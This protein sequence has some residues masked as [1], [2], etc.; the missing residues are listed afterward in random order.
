MNSPERVR[1]RRI[2]GPAATLLLILLVLPFVLYAVGRGLDFGD[3][4][5]RAASRFLSGGPAA[6][7]AIYA[8]MALGGALTGLAPL[9]LLTAGRARWR[10]LHRWNGRAVAV[11]AVLT[12]LGGLVYI[13]AQGTIGGPD[14]TAAFSLYGFLLLGAAVMTWR[15]ARARAPEHPVWAGRLVILAVASWIYRLHYGIWVTAVGEVGMA[16]D[17]SGAFD[18]VNV[19][20]FFLP[21]L[22]AYELLRPRA[23]QA[24]T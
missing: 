8:H 22:L 12:G 1:W 6:D 5:E 3:P 11:L 14:M 4:D 16:P 10:R 7:L 20:A 19:W 18:R 21:Y 15:S 2:A 13:A 9:Q 23:V 17:F 24:R